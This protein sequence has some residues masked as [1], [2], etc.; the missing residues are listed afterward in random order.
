[1]GA[2]LGSV[3]SLLDG[4]LLFLFFVLMLVLLE[5][6]SPPP[7]G[8]SFGVSCRLRGEGD[9]PFRGWG[10][11]ADFFIVARLIFRF[12]HVLIVEFMFIITEVL[13]L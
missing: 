2:L 6:L 1:M 8:V 13:F 11:V 4:G 9:V 5:S 3:E 7:G 10:M 12:Q